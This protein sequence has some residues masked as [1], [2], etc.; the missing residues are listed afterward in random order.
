MYYSLFLILTLAFVIYRDII[1]TT[2]IIIII[3]II[4]I[5]ITH[6]IQ[7][8]LD[9][10]LNIKLHQAT[11][12]ATSLYF[13]IFAIRR[14]SHVNLLACSLLFVYQNNIRSPCLDNVISLN[15]KIPQDLALIVLHYTIWFMLIP[16]QFMV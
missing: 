3:I 6:N 5:D 15:C 4:I 11:S 12:L 9:I 14:A 7:S 10:N 13:S 8:I 16:L 1:I 2:I